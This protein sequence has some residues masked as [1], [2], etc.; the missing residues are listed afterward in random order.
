[1]NG[2]PSN[3]QQRF[4]DELRQICCIVTGSSQVEIHHIFGSK[5]KAKGFKKP[6][7]WLV[8]PL[9]HDVHVDIDSYDFDAE[10]ELFLKTL[11]TYI[12]CYGKLPPIPSK[13]IEY[14][15]NMRHRQDITRCIS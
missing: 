10:R 6:G 11:R 2:N 14:Y 9:H 7:E 13:L 12:H 1:M 5:W 3:E 8:M 4:H 15:R